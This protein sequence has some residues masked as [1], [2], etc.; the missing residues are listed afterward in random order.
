VIAVVIAAL[1]RDCNR[2]F[3]QMS[4]KNRLLASGGDD[5]TETVPGS[6]QL[7]AATKQYKQRN[8]KAE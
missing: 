1:F 8:S 6:A 3:A 2:N 5:L 4:E 7:P